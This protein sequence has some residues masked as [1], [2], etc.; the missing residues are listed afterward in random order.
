[1]V[2][3]DSV[4][5]TNIPTLSHNFDIFYGSD[6]SSEAVVSNDSVAVTIIP[7]LY[8]TLL[9]FMVQTLTL[10][11]WYPITQRTLLLWQ[12]FFMTLFPRKI[13]G[14]WNTF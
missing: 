2:S 13:R 10:G 6:S 1:V 11:T 3:N 8:S 12:I 7:T 4:A 14:F 9:F 5:V